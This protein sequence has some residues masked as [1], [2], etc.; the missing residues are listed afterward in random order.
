MTKTICIRN[1]AL[2][3]DEFQRAYES[4]LQYNRFCHRKDDKTICLNVE[5]TPTYSVD[6]G[7]TIDGVK[8]ATLALAFYLKPYNYAIEIGVI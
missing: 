4:V 2:T 5:D 1:I 6:C 7:A 8:A 3:S